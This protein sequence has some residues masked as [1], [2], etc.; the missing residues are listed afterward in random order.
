M[1]KA[2]ISF[3]LILIMLKL[4]S[5]VIINEIE[6]NPTEGK[7][8]K[9]WVE[10][11]NDEDIEIDISSWE[12]YDGL[13]SEKKRYTFLEG[14]ILEEDSYITIDLGYSVLNNGGDYL[15]LYDKNKEEIDRTPELKETT[16][17]E[18]TW[19]Y[20]DE[21]VFS[22]ETK[23]KE[24][25]CVNEIKKEII[26]EEP[27]R[28]TEENNSNSQN[29]ETKTKDPITFQAIN[30]NPKAIKSTS[31]NKGLSKDYAIYGIIG[32]GILITLLFILKKQRYKKNEFDEVQ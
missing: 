20:C 9:E 6:I 25:N 7:Q 31:D 2:W 13:A 18:K 4:V 32:F 29:T 3:I 19:Q 15:I 30:L 22:E 11:Y 17:S 10:I 8:G 21:W 14:T 16:A 23:N 27:N 1:K 28:N 5:S 24:N 12:I 26:D